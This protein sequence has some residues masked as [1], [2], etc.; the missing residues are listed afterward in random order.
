MVFFSRALRRSS[1]PAPPRSALRSL[2]F[3]PLPLPP[4]LV[5][6]PSALSLSPSGPSSPFPRLPIPPFV[7]ALLGHSLKLLVST[8]A[9]CYLMGRAHTYIPLLSFL[10]SH[11]FLALHLSSSLVT[12]SGLVPLFP[13]PFPCRLHLV[14]LWGAP[15]VLS[16]MLALCPLSP[17]HAHTH[18]LFLWAPHSSS[19]SYACTLPPS[20]SCSLS[21]CSPRPLTPMFLLVVLQHSCH[22]FIV[23][24]ACATY[25]YR[26]LY[27]LMSHA[28]YP[29]SRWLVDSLYPARQLNALM[30]HAIHL[31]G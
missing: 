22:I 11:C 27:A 18:F 16:S 24:T 25:Y 28:I 19:P 9:C 29:F 3:S 13:L 26:C 1:S 12:V 5:F 21:P 15:C 30:T 10:H 4:F 2:L 31:L 20:P 8:R 14:L 23:T 7:V 17:S 6:P